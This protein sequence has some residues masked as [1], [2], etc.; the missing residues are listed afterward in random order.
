[1]VGITLIL[2]FL[3][4]KPIGAYQLGEA[5]CAEYGGQYPSVFRVLLDSAF[6]CIFRNV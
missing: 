2:T 6:Q 1:M 4:S 5:I 3:L